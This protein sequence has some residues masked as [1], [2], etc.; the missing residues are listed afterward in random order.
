M[1]AAQFPW[2][3]APMSTNPAVLQ[4]G[5]SPMAIVCRPGGAVCTEPPRTFLARARGTAE[6]KVARASCGAVPRCVTPML[7]VGAAELV[8]T[9]VV[10]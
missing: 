2:P 8:V 7:P 10:E 4:P 5:I 6:I 3:S 1:I 9:V